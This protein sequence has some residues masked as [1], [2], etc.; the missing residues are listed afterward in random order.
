MKILYYLF[1]KQFSLIF[2]DCEVNSITS[3]SIRIYFQILI[4]I[5]YQNITHMFYLFRSDYLETQIL[6]FTLVPTH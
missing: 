6:L 4:D 2:A 3:K 1:M 5:Y